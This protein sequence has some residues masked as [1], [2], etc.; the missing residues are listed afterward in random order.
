MVERESV[1]RRIDRFVRAEMKTARIPGIALALTD[2]EFL[3]R[4]STYGYADLSA[5]AR[6]TPETLFEIGSIG[7]SFTAIALLQEVEAGRLDLQAPITDYLPWIAVRSPYGPITAHH[8][9]SHTAGLI[10]GTEFSTEAR[11]ETWALRDTEVGFPPGARFHYSNVGYK[12]LGLLLEALTGKHPGEVIRSCILEPLGMVATAPRITHETRTRLAVGYCDL[13]DDRPSS[14]RHP[15]V[16]ATWLETD[17]ADGSIATTAEDLA[18]Y[19]RML[20]NRGRGPQGPILSEESFRLLTRRVIAC[21]E[22][23]RAGFYGY[24]LDVTEQNGHAM[25]G[26]GGGMVGYISSVLMDADAG[27]GVVVLTN[28]IREI[29]GIAQA[30]MRLLRA[31]VAGERLPRLPGPGNPPKVKR[32]ADYAGT[33]RG[34]AKDLVVEAEG[35]R[36]VLRLDDSDV[37]L[38][39]RGAD[40]FYVDHP[41]LDRFLLSFRRYDDRVVE[42]FYGPDRF[43]RGDDAGPTDVG[44]PSAWSAF[45]GHYRAHNPWFPNFRVVVQKDALVLIRPEG[46]EEPLVPLPSGAFRVGKEEHFPERIRFETILD[47]N[48]LRA[49]LSGCDYYRTFTP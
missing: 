6:V 1:F 40:R 8:L 46:I 23:T 10:M 24:G 14:P 21:D 30:S 22:G 49:N 28:A 13:Y 42:V 11:F 33:Y 36:L 4:A 17:T 37:L 27:L 25:L 7:K 26:H 35:D 48:A 32:P 41:D 44:A 34:R 2:R 29:S 39:S 38:E 43:V 3:V 31:G 19:L 9:L 45:A 18:V 15:L 5:R 16:P 20:L 47:G 12:A